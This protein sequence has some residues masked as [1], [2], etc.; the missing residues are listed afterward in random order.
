MGNKLSNEEK[1]ER[2]QIVNNICNLNYN[3]LDLENRTSFTNYID[4]IKPNELGE[5]VDCAKGKDNSLRNFFVFKA[6]F[7]FVNEKY[8][9]TFTIFFQ[10]YSD[11][12]LVWHCCGHSGPYLMETTGGTNNHQFRLIYELLKDGNVKL[13]KEKCLDCRL[14]FTNDYSNF[15][16]I[17]DLEFPIE[18]KLFYH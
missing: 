9:D 12:K 5:Q 8:F 16:K 7:N 15:D 14:N 10:R 13:N 6:R 3:T 17:S 11:D 4:F 18:V 1:E 2:E